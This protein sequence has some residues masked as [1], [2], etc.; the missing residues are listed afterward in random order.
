MSVTDDLITSEG[1]ET[2]QGVWLKRPPLKSMLDGVD[3]I[4]P[5]GMLYIGR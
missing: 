3:T 1:F 5:I 4:H 2:S